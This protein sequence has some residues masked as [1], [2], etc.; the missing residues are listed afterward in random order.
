MARSVVDLKGFSELEKALAELPKNIGRGVAR[1]AVKR[2]G[3]EMAQ[4]QRDLAPVD[5]GAFRDSIG[6]KITTK[7]LVGLAEFGAT[8]RGGGSRDDAVAALRTARREAK[9]SGAHKGH[10]IAVNVGPASPLAPLIEYGTGPRQHKKGK[11]TG[12]MPA[13]PVVRP[14][15]DNGVDQSIETIREGLIEEMDKAAT[16]MARRAARR[17]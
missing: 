16:R 3:D 12:V 4:K 8:L 5:Q 11:S 17:R 6:T 10:R 9:A 14:A 7:N 2:A 1:R 15:F 13:S